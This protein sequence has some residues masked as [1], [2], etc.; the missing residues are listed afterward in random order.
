VPRGFSAK[1]EWAKK[2]SIPIVSERWLQQCIAQGRL[3]MTAPFRPEIPENSEVPLSLSDSCCNTTVPQYFFGC[4]I[5]L[6]DACQDMSRLQ[7]LKKLIVLPG[8]LRYSSF[9]NSECT[10]WIVAK[11]SVSSI[12][13]SDLA[14]KCSQNPLLHVVHDSWLIDSYKAGKRL[15]ERHYKFSPPIDS[16]TSQS[17]I[18]DS[19]ELFRVP[20]QRRGASQQTIL[21][22]IEG[23]NH[24]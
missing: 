13:Y 24:K 10:H 9:D 11:Q 6:S 15:D 14:Q 5:F 8:G 2:W 3:L 21:A 12:S 19:H 7:I 23:Q 20:V 4:R 17:T 18:L 22:R 16:T 1:Y